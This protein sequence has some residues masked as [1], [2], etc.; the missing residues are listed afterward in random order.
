MKKKKRLFAVLM[1]LSM[2]FS[3][4]PVNAEAEN[5]GTEDWGTTTGVRVDPELPV[6]EVE[7][8]YGECLAQAELKGIEGAI[9]GTWTFTDAG[10]FVTDEDVVTKRTFEL[11][12]RP[13][14]NRHYNSV[15][16][17][18]PVEKLNK[19][20]VITAYLGIEEISYGQKAQISYAVEAN[21]F[22]TAEETDALFANVTKEMTLEETGKSLDGI[23][24]AGYYHIKCPETVGG[25]RVNWIHLDEYDL[26]INPLIIMSLQSRED[27]VSSQAGTRIVVRAQKKRKA[28]GQEWTDNDLSFTISD[29]ERSKLLPG[30][31]VEDL[32]ITLKATTIKSEN[33]MNGST[34]DADGDEI[35]GKYGN[36]GTYLI[37]KA[38]A[39]NSNYDVIVIPS[40]LEITPKEASLNWNARSQY[41]YTGNS[42]GIQAQVASES[43][44]GR[45]SCEVVK[46]FNA[47]NTDAGVYQAAAV[48][49]TNGNYYLP[50]TQAAR[51]WQYEITQ[52][53]P[54]VTCPTAE[55]TYGDSLKEAEFTNGSGDGAF[56]FVDDTEKLS[57]AE[58]GSQKEM[59][60]IPYNPNYKGATLKVPVTVRPKP[61]QCVWNTEGTIAFTGKEVNVTAGLSGVLPGDDCQAV[62]EGGTALNPGKYTAKV[63]GLTGAQKENYVLQGEVSKEYQIVASNSGKSDTKDDTED[64]AKNSTKDKTKKDVKE[65]GKSV[66]NVLTGEKSV[67]TGDPLEFNWLMMITGAVVLAGMLLYRRKSSSMHF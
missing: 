63:T 7:L 47:E 50:K 29:E 14:D 16:M 33:I 22:L 67:R 44:L 64:T 31:T 38:N 19:S 40:F 28:Y 20:G 55:I 46:I 24:N 26:V 36:K 21:D 49:M 60:F 25:F 3:V 52:A 12:F 48:G 11:T 17:Q 39:T 27:K 42:F 13:K 23:L 15:T 35:L 62:V 34:T 57:V 10:Y 54:Q 5:I 56:K 58:T 1:C 6:P 30:D 61:V 32:G 51:S 43:L 4:I 37:T 18:V 66:K 45:D 2:A 65:N 41:T 53:E 9:E 59:I 8:N